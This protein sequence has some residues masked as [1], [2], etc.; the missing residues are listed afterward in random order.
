MNELLNCATAVYLQVF[1]YPLS[2]DLVKD[3][4]NFEVYHVNI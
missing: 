4:T 1:L 2:I 3:I